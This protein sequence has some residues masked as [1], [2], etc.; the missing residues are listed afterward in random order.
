MLVTQS[1]EGISGRVRAC[2]QV[3]EG[4]TVGSL[5][6]VRGGR[7]VSHDAEAREGRRSAGSVKDF[8]KGI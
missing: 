4:P 1:E 3:K 6:G 5:H 2:D 7:R 8:R